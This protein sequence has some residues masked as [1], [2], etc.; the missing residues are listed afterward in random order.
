MFKS[1]ISQKLVLMIGLGFGLSACGAGTLESNH[2]FAPTDAELDEIAVG[3]DTQDTVSTVVGPPSTSGAIRDEAWYY[4][5]STFESRLY[6]KPKEVSREV[7]A[8]SFDDEGVVQNIERFGLEDGQVVVL[9]RRVT[10]DNI[11]GISFLRQLLGNIGN[12]N[13]ADALG[14]GDN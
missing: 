3:I 4:V 9:N 6:F 2:G 12:F 11:Q 13:P 14:G 1:G 10:D 7:V 8:I 5:A